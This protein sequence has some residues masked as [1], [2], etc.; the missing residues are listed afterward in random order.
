MNIEKLREIARKMGV[1][2]RFQPSTPMPKDITELGK[3]R[4]A[5]FV[6]AVKPHGAAWPVQFFNAINLSRRRYDN[7][8]HEMCQEKRAD[9]WTVLYCVPRVKPCAPRKYFSAERL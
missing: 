1:D 4:L 9:G 5:K 6:V 7:G 2:T 3:G 8:T